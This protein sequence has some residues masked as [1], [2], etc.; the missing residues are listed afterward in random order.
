M[1]YLSLLLLLHVRTG[2][3]ARRIVIGVS[4]P[5]R[6]LN[7]FRLVLL[8]HMRSKRVTSLKYLRTLDTLMDNTGDVSLNM[9]FDS[10]LKLV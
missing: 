7:S 3:W 4:H 8:N 9:L 6:R 5:R 10:K 1:L 2:A